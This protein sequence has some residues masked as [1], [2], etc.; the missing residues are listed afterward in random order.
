MVS[1]GHL[2]HRDDRKD[3][4]YTSLEFW[5]VSLIIKTMELIQGIQAEK[6][7]KKGAQH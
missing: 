3:A 6:V 5:S 4:E 1:L 2:L 7:Q